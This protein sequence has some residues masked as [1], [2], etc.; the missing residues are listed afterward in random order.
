MCTK[1]VTVEAYSKKETA[2]LRASSPKSAN[3]NESARPSGTHARVWRFW[4]GYAASGEKAKARMVQNVHVGLSGFRSWGF[5]WFPDEPSHF[6][7]ALMALLLGSRPSAVLT[8]GRSLVR[9]LH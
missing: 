9:G 4:E 5:I 7:K 2:N 3:P 6:S 8:A 1:F